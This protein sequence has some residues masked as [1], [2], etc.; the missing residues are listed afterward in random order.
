MCAEVIKVAAKV[1]P[2]CQIHQSRYGRVRADLKAIAS[3]LLFLV[4]C[5]PLAVWLLDQSR[6][7]RERDFAPH[8]NELVVVDTSLEYGRQTP[9]TWLASLGTNK[10]D[11]KWS[12]LQM[13]V[14]FLD[15]EGSP[16]DVWTPAPPV[17]YVKPC[18]WLMGFVTNTGK[19]PWRI[20]ELEARFLDSQS[21]LIDV[22]N[23]RLDEQSSVVQPHSRNAFR[24][25]LSTT[26]SFNTNAIRLV[27][28]QRASEAR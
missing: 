26:A 2:F 3:G 22:Q 28:V 10:S 1:C 19:Y 17:A 7:E 4:I 12:V 27:R 13:E 16:L 18:L 20:Q 5:L 11:S 14:R 15:P 21:N 6:P 23:L 25:A 8:R 24:L 9:D